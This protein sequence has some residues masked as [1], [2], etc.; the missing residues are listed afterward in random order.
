MSSQGGII[1]QKTI[2]INIGTDGS[3]SRTELV[4]GKIQL[5]L[6]HPD[7]QEYYK[8]GIWQ[9]Q[10][11]NIGDNFKDYGKV[12]LTNT[13]EK[14]SS[15]KIYTRS[16]LDGVN[17]TPWQETSSEGDILSP[18]NRFVQ[19]R[20]DLYAGAT[21]ETIKIT[22]E[23]FEEANPFVEKT[24]YEQGSYQIPTLTSN[25]PTTFG[26]PFAE[27]SYGGGND[28]W[29]AFDNTT[30]HYTTANSKPLGFIGYSFTNPVKI[31]KYLLQSTNISNQS[32]M[33]KDW[34]FEGS[35]NTTNG[36]DGT[37]EILDTRSDQVWTMAQV[38]EY[39]I[40]NEKEY[41]AYRVKWS[42]NNGH[43]S[44]SS[45]GELNFQSATIENIQLK[46]NY[47]YDMVQDTAWTD[48][49]SLHRKSITSSEWL[50][51]DRLDVK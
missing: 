44:L 30:A 48:T 27:S 49:G 19:I 40:E 29:R 9:S 36:A 5:K 51:I 28:I 45:I 1:E 4:D 41:K 38:R 34:V 10:I 43:A 50:K 31:V 22:G 20:L 6:E 21:I 8:M 18:K 7:T 42:A 15:V 12:I 26:F 3:F 13:N 33:I 25:A 11:I 39:S 46:R 17:F 47:N 23:S 24:V 16:S 35:N 2:G 37:W 14:G 32:T